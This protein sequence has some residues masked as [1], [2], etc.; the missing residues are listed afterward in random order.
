MAKHENR[1]EVNKVLFE[2]VSPSWENGKVDERFRRCLNC[3][4]FESFHRSLGLSV[5][6]PW[7]NEMFLT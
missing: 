4:L 2:Q 6:F 7:R 5:N 3:S 1:I